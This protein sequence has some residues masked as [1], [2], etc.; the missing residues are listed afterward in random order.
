MKITYWMRLKNHPGVPVATFVSFLF[1][2]VGLLNE[3]LDFLGGLVIGGIATIPVWAIVLWT[4]R[5][6][7]VSE[8]P[9]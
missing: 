4:A 9:K 3:N 2:L 8:N 1:P 6:Q 5:T 7:P